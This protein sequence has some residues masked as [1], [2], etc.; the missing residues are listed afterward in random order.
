MSKMVFLYKENNTED[1]DCVKYIKNEPMRFECNHY[2][3]G[4]NLEGA[5]FSCG[6]NELEALN[7]EDITTILT[8]DEINLLI[9]FGEDINNLGY[10]IKIDDDRYNKGIRLC[11]EI[12]PVYD[13]LNSKENEELFNKVVEEEKEWMKEEYSLSDEDIEDIFDDYYLEYRDRGILGS[14]YGDAEELGRENFD[15]L[16]FESNNTIIERY[17]NFKEFGEDLLEEDSYHE[18]DDG[19]IISL[20]Y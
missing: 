6:L 12:Q 13:K 11:Q 17:F 2:F 16:G 8:K 14:I 10:G 9:K 19:R 1:R 18:L 15:Y 20:N 7:Y 3:G 4:V 5:C